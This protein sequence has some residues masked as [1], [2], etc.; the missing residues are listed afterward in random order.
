MGSIVI[1][2]QARTGN[3]CFSSSAEAE[4]ALMR[5]ENQQRKEP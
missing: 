1:C 4:E 5:P 2:P 3:A